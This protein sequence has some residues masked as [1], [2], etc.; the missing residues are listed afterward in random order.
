V[1]DLSSRRGQYRFRA[2]GRWWQARSE[3]QPSGWLSRTGSIQSAT[4]S[5]RRSGTRYA[6]GVGCPGE[7]PPAVWPHPP[8]PVVDLGPMASRLIHGDLGLERGPLLGAPLTG[9]AQ[10]ARDRAYAPPRKPRHSRTPGH[11]EAL[12]GVGPAEARGTDRPP[13]RPHAGDSGNQCPGVGVV[14][15]WN[16]HPRRSTARPQWATPGKPPRTGGLACAP[17]TTPARSLASWLA[18]V[19]RGIARN[20]EGSAFL[21]TVTRQLGFSRPGV[22]LWTASRLCGVGR[23]ESDSPIQFSPPDARVQL[24]SCY[25]ILSNGAISGSRS[26][27]LRLGSGG[28][29]RMPGPTT[30]I[31]AV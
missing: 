21:A 11:S 24:A 4:L 16:E 19:P 6:P 26:Q 22:L 8:P 13:N 20:T 7:S 28:R 2:A 9:G 23:R 18:R 5:C 14:I 29:R 15:G 12:P 27:R 31:P 3:V 30:P 25:A 10:P 1:T 17:H